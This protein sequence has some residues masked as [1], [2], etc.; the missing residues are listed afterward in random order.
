MDEGSCPRGK[1]YILEVGDNER[2]WTDSCDRADGTAAGMMTTMRVLFA[3][4]VPDF[5]E[6]VKNTG[7]TL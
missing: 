2:R 3:K 4:Q 5:D 1:R 6:L 7:L